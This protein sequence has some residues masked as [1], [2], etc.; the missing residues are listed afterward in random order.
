MNAVLDYLRVVGTMAASTLSRDAQICDTQRGTTLMTKQKHVYRQ[1]QRVTVTR[2]PE[3]SKP[4]GLA[5]RAIIRGC[6]SRVLLR[7]RLQ[8]T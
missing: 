5:A 8:Y 3:R 6:R 1:R 2:R 7:R 4:F